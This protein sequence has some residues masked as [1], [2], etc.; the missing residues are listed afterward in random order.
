MG[1]FYACASWADGAMIVVI[2]RG[3]VGMVGRAGDTGVGERLH[4]CFLPW[5]CPSLMYQ[6]HNNDKVTDE[7]FDAAGTTIR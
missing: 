7:V 5:K 2:D 3:L 6:R 4:A 1:T